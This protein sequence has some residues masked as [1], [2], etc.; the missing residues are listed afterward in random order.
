MPKF[1]TIGY[2]DPADYDR[3]PKSARDAAH[4]QDAKLRSDGAVMGIAGEP[5]QVRNPD[6]HGVET[7]DGPFMSSAL[8]IAGFAIIEAADL[9]EAIKKVSCVPCAVAHGVVEVWPLKQA[10]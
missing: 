8:P 7:R 6:A 4:A 2:G 5:V 1:I 3:T 9:S 10:T